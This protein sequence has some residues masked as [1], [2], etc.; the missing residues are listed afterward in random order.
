L[1]R[2]WRIVPVKTNIGITIILFF[3]LVFLFG[4]SANATKHIIQSRGITFSPDTLTGVQ[5]G[6][7]IRWEWASNSH[8]T[9]S[10]GYAKVAEVRLINL[11]IFSQFLA[12]VIFWNLL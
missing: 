4:V 7:T 2:V 12:K 3:A 10:V 9:T 5:I 11:C 8:M 1:V 6:D